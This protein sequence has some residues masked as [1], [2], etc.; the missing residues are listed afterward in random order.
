[1]VPR[2]LDAGED[3]GDGAEAEQ[4]AGDGGQL[5]GVTVLEVGDDLDEFPFICSVYKLCPFV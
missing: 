2:L 3:P 5:T 4:E 1:M